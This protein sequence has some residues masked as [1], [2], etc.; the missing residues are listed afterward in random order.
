MLDSRHATY[1]TDPERISVLRYPLSPRRDPTS[2][3]RCL[4]R[5]LQY[6]W[7]I[8]CCTRV[9]DRQATWHTTQS[10]CVTSSL[11]EIACRQSTRTPRQVISFPDEK[12]KI[13][14]ISKLNHPKINKLVVKDGNG[15]YLFKNDQKK[16]KKK[17]IIITTTNQFLMHKLKADKCEPRAYSSV[18]GDNTLRDDFVDS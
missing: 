18:N 4:F 8:S 11:Q 7:L 14:K 1:C 16:F 6:S 9:A 2:C 12:D 5:V 13:F 3:L 10:A 17:R 15:F